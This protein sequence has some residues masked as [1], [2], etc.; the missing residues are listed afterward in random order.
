MGKFFGIIGSGLQTVYS[1][2]VIIK[3]MIIFI[4]KISEVY[5]FSHK[6]RE[7]EGD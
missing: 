2:S 6:G 3:S 5:W 1:Y 7:I 4:I